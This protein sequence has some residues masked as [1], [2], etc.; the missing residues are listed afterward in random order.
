MRRRA[1]GF[2]LSLS[3]RG[4]GE[5]SAWDDDKVQQTRMYVSTYVFDLLRQWQTKSL[6][7]SVGAL[8]AV[9]VEAQQATGSSPSLFVKG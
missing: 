3:I 1:G 5:K 9:K 8:G 6:R 7:C 4:V 2:S